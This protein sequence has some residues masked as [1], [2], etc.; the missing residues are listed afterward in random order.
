MQILHT[1]HL[2]ESRGFD[3]DK[4]PALSSVIHQNVYMFDESILDNICLHEDYSKEELQSA[5][6]DSGLLHFIEQVPNAYF[7][8]FLMDN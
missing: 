7:F 2:I 4:I 5:L 8:P 1:N 6:S 3:I